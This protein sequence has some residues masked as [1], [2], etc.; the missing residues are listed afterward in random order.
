MKKLLIVM[1][2]S[3]FFLISCSYSFNE[4]MES[5]WGVQIPTGYKEVFSSNSGPSFQGDGWRYNIF[6]YKGDLNIEELEGFTFEKFT[7]IENLIEVILDSLDVPIE[8]RPDFTQNYYWY[9]KSGDRDSRNKL[10][11]VYFD[12]IN[13]LYVIQDIY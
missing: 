1:L 5:N 9:R 8:E 6:H 2:L 3:S 10:Y 11:L 7:G 12:K 4:V 13:M